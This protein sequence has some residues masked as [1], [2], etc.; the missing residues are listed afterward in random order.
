VGRGDPPEAR[1]FYHKRSRSFRAKFAAMWQLGQGW[2][3]FDAMRTG[4]SWFRFRRI[5]SKKV[6]TIPVV[7][8]RTARRW[9]K[10]Q[11]W[12]PSFSRS[13]RVTAYDHVP[14]NS[15]AIAYIIGGAHRIR[16]RG[17]PRLASARR[18]L[19]QRH[20]P[21]QF[22]AQRAERARPSFSL[23]RF[24]CRHRKHSRRF[25]SRIWGFWRSTSE[26]GIGQKDS[27][28]LWNICRLE[29]PGKTMARI[30][31]CAWGGVSSI[32]SR[33]FK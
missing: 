24:A 25:F 16:F 8:S 5:A 23:R 4:Q 7:R 19:G 17:L 9:P 14:S 13:R 30:L 6:R 18:A 2:G 22:E 11:M 28:S 15:E 3:G 26:L 10:G 12:G 1:R 29:C 33:G 32:S 27:L 20:D 31:L 21:N